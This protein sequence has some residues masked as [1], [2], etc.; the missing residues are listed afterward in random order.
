MFADYYNWAAKRGVQVGVAH[1]HRDIHAHTGILDFERG[2]EEQLTPY[3]WLTDTS[4]GPWFH[5]KSVAYKSVDDIVDVLVDIV[6]KNGCML[7]N[8]GPAADG[9]I[10]REARLLL[11]CLG[12]WLEVNGD[13]IYDTRPW[14]IH[15]E[16]P[17]RN[18]GG[19]FSEKRDR[20][21]TGRDLRFTRSKDGKTLYAIALGWPEERL[22]LRS[23]RVDSAG[24]EARV[25]LLGHHDGD[26][27]FRV[28]EEKQLV[29]Q[30]PNLEPDERPCGQA[31][32]FKLT[33]FALSLHPEARFHLPGA[34][35]V[36]VEK[37]TLE[38]ERV[39]VQTKGGRPNIGAWDDPGERAHW[40]VWIRK[41]ATYAARGEFSAGYGPSG[42]KTTLAGQ[43]GATPIPRT[44]GWYKPVFVNLGRFK[45][46]RPGVYRLTLEPTG[47][48]KAVNVWQLQLAPVP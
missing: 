30:R 27:S 10:P 6:S 33:G 29:I 4:V 44:D 45:V 24:P 39:L 47:K 28:N 2:R 32:A 43:A 16:G 46:D 31:F 3:P 21:Y 23:V 1:K 34:I 37:V 18:T 25:R 42:L 41:A 15:G 36:P 48:W 9:T 14:L 11:L 17:T 5:Q 22:T 35:D 7:L 38:G 12:A 20:P 8:V 13:A 19:G 40:L 26:V